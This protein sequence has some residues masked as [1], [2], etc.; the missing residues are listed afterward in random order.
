MQIPMCFAESL[1]YLCVCVL[2]RVWLFATLWTTAHQA[3]LS[4]GFFWQKHWSGLPFLTSGELPNPGINPASPALTSDFFTSVLP[5][6][7]SAAFFICPAMKKATSEEDEP[8]E[9]DKIE[10]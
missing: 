2:S 9:D 5:G 1:Q 7:P 4:M 10:N 6:K 8:R 3:L